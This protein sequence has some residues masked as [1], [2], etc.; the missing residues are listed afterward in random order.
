MRVRSR[1]G[2]RKVLGVGGG[3]G[4]GEGWGRGCRSVIA[5]IVL[6]VA[7]GLYMGLVAS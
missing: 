5:H 4:T 6:L 2:R 7:V 1:R 3:A